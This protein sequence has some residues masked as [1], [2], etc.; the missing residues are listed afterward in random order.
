MQQPKYHALICTSCRLNGVIKGFC[1]NHDSVSLLQNLT[2][3]IDDAGIGSD[4]MVT[5]TGCFG[6]CE[7]GPVMVVY[8][9]GVWYGQLDEAKIERIVSEHFCNGI[10]VAEFRI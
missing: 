4:I 6:L 8:P 3:Q 9:E 7:K 2:E 10:P 5:H 1:A